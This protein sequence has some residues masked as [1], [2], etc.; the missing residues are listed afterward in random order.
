[1]DAP[2]DNSGREQSEYHLMKHGISE[3]VVVARD[4]ECKADDE[5]REHGAALCALLVR[6][7]PVEQNTGCIDHGQLVHELHGI[8][9]PSGRFC[10]AN[11]IRLT[12]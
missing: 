10:R 11:L 1:M 3:V 6:N 8:C 2:D 9:I 7:D 4:E 12:L 5:D